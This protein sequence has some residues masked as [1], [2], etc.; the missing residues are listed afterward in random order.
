MATNMMCSFT[1]ADLEEAIE[2]IRIS[3][4]PVLRLETWEGFDPTDAEVIGQNLQFN[5]TVK[6]LDLSNNNMYGKCASAIMNALKNNKTITCI[7]LSNNL[8]DSI[9]YDFDPT[10]EK[11]KTL[12]TIILTGNVLTND[13]AKSMAKMILANEALEEIYIEGNHIGEKKLCRIAC[14]VSIE[15]RKSWWLYDKNKKKLLLA[16]SE[17]LEAAAKKACEELKEAGKQK[18]A[19]KFSRHKPKNSDGKQEEQGSKEPKYFNAFT[20]SSSFSEGEQTES[21][22]S[23]VEGEY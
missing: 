20:K 18:A 4:E 14:C 19:E 5:T 13:C 12:K 17:E 7:D 3:K 10:A 15:L 23:S 21:D 1:Q 8:I 11:N 2:A 22:S 16:N 9:S 6:F